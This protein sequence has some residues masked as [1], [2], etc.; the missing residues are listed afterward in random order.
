MKTTW[1]SLGILLLAFASRSSSGD[2]H[3]RL[4]VRDREVTLLAREVEGS[5]PSWAPDGSAIVVGSARGGILIVPVA[6]TPVHVITGNPFHNGP[7]WAPTDDRIAFVDESQQD[8][9]DVYLVEYLRNLEPQRLPLSGKVYV[10]EQPWS[11]DGSSLL[12]WTETGDVRTFGV[13]DQKSKSVATGG[14]GC[15]RGGIS[16]LRWNRTG[17]ITATGATSGVMILRPGDSTWRC[18][19]ERPGRQAIEGPNGAVWWIAGRNT[20]EVY[21]GGEEARITLDGDVSSL[22][23]NPRNGSA[24]VA[25]FK[26]GLFL[27]SSDGSATSL[28]IGPNEARTSSGVGTERYPSDGVPV[29]SPDGTMVAFVRLEGSSSADLCVISVEE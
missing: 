1:V 11:P 12:Y 10:A 15:V 22:D 26:K 9:K 3:D 14:G 21:R 4:S 16:Q 17:S 29:W 7:T 20:L 25:I 13:A 6:H 27:V 23:V 5:A 18:L 2:E 19:S 8:S 24:V 28:L